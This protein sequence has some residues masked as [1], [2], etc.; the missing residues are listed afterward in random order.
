MPISGPRTL[1][2]PNTAPKM[3]CTAREA[4]SSAIEW[5]SPEKTDPI[6]KITIAAWK[7]CLR[8]YRSPSFPHSGVEAVEA[9]RYGA[10]SAGF[11]RLLRPRSRA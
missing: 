8:P 7:N 10:V 1:V 9:S 6:R 5:A 11:G 4:I 3:P 2:T